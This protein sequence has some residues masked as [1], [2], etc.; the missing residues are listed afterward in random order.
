MVSRETAKRHRR[1]GPRVMAGFF[2]ASTLFLSSLAS[3]QDRERD[4]DRYR[5]GKESRH[6][7]VAP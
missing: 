2:I 4:Q 7:Y 5:D 6:L 1:S 3:A